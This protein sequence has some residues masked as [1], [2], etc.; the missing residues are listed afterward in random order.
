MLCLL[1]AEYSFDNLKNVSDNKV[2][3]DL[4]P[5]CSVQMAMFAIGGL[6]VMI[7]RLPS[8]EEV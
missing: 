3:V 8:A 6:F 5:C 2:N 1:F 4:F 7:L